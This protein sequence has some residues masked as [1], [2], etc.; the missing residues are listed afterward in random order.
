MEYDGI[1]Q[2]YTRLLKTN[3]NIDCFIDIGSGRGKLCF[4]MAAK[5]KIKHVLGVELVE[6]RH[7][8]ATILKSELKTEYSKKVELFNSNIFDIDLTKHPGKTP[9][10]WFSNLCFDQSIT[11]KIFDKLTTELPEGSFI[12]CS[13]NPENTNMKKLDQIQIPMSWSTTSNVYIYQI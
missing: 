9:F 10:I 6:E 4:Y 11:D 7:N 1:E 8:D 2:L 5:P 12:C 13:K 3:A